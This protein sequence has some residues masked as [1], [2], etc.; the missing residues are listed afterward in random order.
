MDNSRIIQLIENPGK[1]KFSD[2]NYIEDLITKYP[3]AQSFHLVYLNWK[4]RYISDSLNKKDLQKISI[5]TSYRELIKKSTD[6]N[7]KLMKS[8]TTTEDIIRE[9]ENKN[10]L[11]DENIILESIDS[12]EFMEEENNLIKLNEIDVNYEK[13]LNKIKTSEELLSDSSKKLDFQPVEDTSKI[14]LLS[15]NEE[16]LSKK[17][18]FLN[19]DILYTNIEKLGISHLFTSNFGTQ[20]GS[21]IENSDIEELNE[22]FD[23]SKIKDA[24]LN[25]QNI[26]NEKENITLGLGKLTFNQWISLSKQKNA[27][28]AKKTIPQQE[29]QNNIISNFIENNPKIKPVAKDTQYSKDVEFKKEEIQD[30]ANLMTITLAQLYVEQGK[31]DTALTAFK[32][33]SLKY[34]EKSSFFASEIRRIK[35]IKNSK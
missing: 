27:S 28:K 1:L 3:F 14:Q 34:P 32:I 22:K 4:N 6:D 30:I 12:N 5:Y 15:S 26:E 35:K 2:K 33:L 24:S 13:I 21:E 31:Y 16:E 8:V 29:R 20:I 19:K 25:D 18:N 7:K 9:E 17:S 23:E 10:L 11:A